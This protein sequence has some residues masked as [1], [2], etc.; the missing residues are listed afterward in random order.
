[1]KDTTLLKIPILD[2]VFKGFEESFV[3]EEQNS[4]DFV[5]K[6]ISTVLKD[7]RGGE[8]TKSCMIN[9]MKNGKQE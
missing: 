9:I 3:G 6:V 1:M 2:T 5:S 8:G 7:V 4:H